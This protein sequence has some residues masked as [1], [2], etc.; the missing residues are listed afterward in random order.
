MDP[1][2]LRCDDPRELGRLNS[3]SRDFNDT[4]RHTW[5]TPVKRE[6]ALAE[7]GVKDFIRG[8]GNVFERLYRDAL[9]RSSAQWPAQP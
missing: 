9:D 1:E 5:L 4:L 6:A 2:T 8:A 3:H 7:S